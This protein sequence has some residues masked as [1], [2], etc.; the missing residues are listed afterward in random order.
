M[1][2]EGL[3]NSTLRAKMIPLQKRSVMGPPFQKVIF[4]NCPKN[5]TYAIFPSPTMVACTNLGATFEERAGSCLG[6]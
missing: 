6:P 2:K 1:A 5:E 3:L 4:P